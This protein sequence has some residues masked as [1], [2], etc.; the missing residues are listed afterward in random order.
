MNSGCGALFPGFIEPNTRADCLRR[1]GQCH[2]YF[3]AAR[4][5]IFSA[6]RSPA[7]FDASLYYRQ[8]KTSS[9]GSAATRWF[10]SEERIENLGQGLFGYAWAFISNPYYNCI[11]LA[12]GRDGDGARWISI[13]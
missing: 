11:V 3:Q 8:S 12:L 10:S 2:Q 5:S 7:C 6:H 1:H 4:L 13:A 9:P